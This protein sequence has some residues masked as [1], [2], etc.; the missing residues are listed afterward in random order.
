MDRNERTLMVLGKE[1]FEKITNSHVLVVGCGGVGGAC[2]ECFVR[3]GIKN[4]TVIDYDIVDVTNLNRQILATTYNIG[5]K[6]VEIA[7][8]RAMSINPRCNFHSLDMFLTSENIDIVG[9]I[10]PDFVVDAI[11]NVS[12]KLA[13]IEYCK[14]TNI[15]IISAMGTG[16]RFDVKGFTIAPVENSAGNG[17]GL[18]RIMRREL[19]KRG[20]KGHMAL[21]NVNAPDSYA[22]N[23]S[24]GRHA[25]GSTVFCPNI[26]GIMIAQYVCEKL[27]EK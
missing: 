7:K 14:K 18:S 5:Q 15:P 13:L 27:K 9:K 19:K 1:N 24:G 6:K 21:F 4:V 22:V 3:F 23:T 25:P 16:N 26:A 11:D 10:S 17:C 20:I 12:A 8:A 2:V